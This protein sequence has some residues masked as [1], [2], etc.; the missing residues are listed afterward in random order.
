[1]NPSNG[2]IRMTAKS[3]NAIIEQFPL[4]FL[5]GRLILNDQDVPQDL[6]I[7]KVNK[8]LEVM[9]HQT[10]KQLIG[11]SARRILLH[12]DVQDEDLFTKVSNVALYGGSDSF[13]LFFP[14]HGRNLSVTL[15]S[16]VRYEVCLIL[17]DITASITHFSDSD[18]FFQISPDLLSI[19]TVDG[20]YIKVNPAWKKILG[21][22]P[23]EIV[24]K[25]SLDFLH[26]EDRFSA[27][28]AELPQDAQQQ[29]LNFSNRFRHQDGSYRVIEWNC[30]KN[31]SR[32]YSIG[33]DIT[34]RNQREE[35][36]EY[37]SFHDVLT[38]LYNRRFLEEEAKR[39]DVP[40][41]LPFT[42][43]MG[44]VN[45]LKLVND[46]FGHEKGDELI[47]LAAESI[48]TSCRPEDLI[49]RWGGD[50]FILFLPKTSGDDAQKVID[51]IHATCATKTVN[52]I[53]VSIAFGYATKNDPSDT[54][55]AKLR[56][57]ED[58]MYKS[59]AKEGERSRRDIIDV[60]A[61]TLYSKIPFEEQHAKR[62][63]FLCRQMATS[64]GFGKED[65]QKMALAGL[66]HDIGKVA[67]SADIL[68]K[69]SPLTIAEWQ[70]LK[71]HTEI[72]AKVVGNGDSMSEIGQAILHHHERYDGSGYPKGIAWDNIPLAARIITI[73]DSY[74]TMISQH[75]YKPAKSRQEAIDELRKNSGTQF[76]PKLAYLFIEAILGEQKNHD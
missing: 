63:S 52:S 75:D 31:H 34:E 58:A 72:G 35:K 5:H 62:V 23:V 49:A 47:K 19:S 4:G 14:D 56:E 1:M 51:R 18:V 15:Y 48:K 20:Q 68:T 69:K 65:I 59:K 9:V 30:R 24:G 55:T 46:A 16:P 54:L 39:M 43:I 60:I 6:I 36:I 57:A 28:Q 40:R 25:L 32:I 76:D 11:T 66:L 50:E 2:G 13:D 22:D 10:S 12:Y 71:T 33:R 45:R 53:G 64:L 27:Q 41:N 17:T 61:A 3:T 70:Q 7:I 44:D 8:A 29:F 73:A 67:I 26:P 21:Y 37:L 38:G 74:D 42:V